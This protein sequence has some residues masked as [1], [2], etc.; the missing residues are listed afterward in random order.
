MH[1]PVQ[2][3][4][5]SPPALASVHVAA[6][7]PASPEL[8]VCVWKQP[9][10]QLHCGSPPLPSVVHAADVVADPEHGLVCAQAPVQKQSELPPS[11]LPL[12]VDWVAVL[13]GLHVGWVHD[14]VQLHCGSPPA[15]SCVQPAEVT[16]LLPVEQV[17]VC[18]H[19]PF[20]SHPLTPVH[21]PE[22]VPLHDATEGP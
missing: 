16:V 3:H 1:V 13:S 12:Q 19:E 15:S 2:L 17:F 20:H 11:P 14:P 9:P 22:V 18:A 6:V 21:V 8:H 5:G 10:V 7:M 4:C